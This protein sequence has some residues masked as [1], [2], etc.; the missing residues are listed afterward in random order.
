M[1]AVP[2]HRRLVEEEWKSL[3]IATGRRRPQD[4]TAF[5]FF[6]KTWKL[7]DIEKVK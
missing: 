7:N 5:E 2:L 1:M 3:T 6:D 4:G